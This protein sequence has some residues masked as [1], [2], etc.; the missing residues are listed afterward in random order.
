[1]SDDFRRAVPGVT[2][3]TNSR[4]A[5]VACNR[6]LLGNLPASTHPSR[7]KLLLFHDNTEEV[8]SSSFPE[9]NLIIGSSYRE[10]RTTHQSRPVSGG[11]E[12]NRLQTNQTNERV[13]YEKEIVGTRIICCLYRY[14]VGWLRIDV[15]P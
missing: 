11:N 7:L 14:S 13:R 5:S 12:E 8:R 4:N 9:Q 1:M 6:H 3:N 2:R 15:R 10:L